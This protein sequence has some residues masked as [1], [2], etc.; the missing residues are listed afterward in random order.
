MPRVE[1]LLAELTSR[2]GLSPAFLAQIRPAAEKILDPALAEET[3]VSLLELLAETCDRHVRIERD[4]KA[5]QAAWAKL[6]SNLEQLRLLFLRLLGG[7]A[8]E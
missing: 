5:T 2:Y 4:S 3:R 8:T 6:S 7:P 1:A